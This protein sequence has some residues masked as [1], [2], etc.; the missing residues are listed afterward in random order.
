MTASAAGFFAEGSTHPTFTSQTQQTRMSAPVPVSTGR[1][2]PVTGHT[3]EQ[4]DEMDG[5]GAKRVFRFKQ[6]FE[7]ETIT[8]NQ[9]ATITRHERSSSPPPPPVQFADQTPR[10]APAPP[11]PPPPPPMIKPDTFDHDKGTF[12]FRD[13]K[14]RARTVRIGRVVWP[15]PQDREEREIRDVGRLEIDE[16]VQRELDERMRPTTIMK[17]PDSPVVERKVSFTESFH[18]VV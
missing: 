4:H 6:H 3:T 5:S 14:G 10:M 12:T 2:F 18:G 15:P 7:K 17:K 13:R 9:E 1:Q 11:P 8:P 16:H